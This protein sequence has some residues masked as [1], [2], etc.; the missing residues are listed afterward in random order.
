MNQKPRLNIES[1]L[2]AGPRS[3]VRYCTA[4]CHP[5]E[6]WVCHRERGRGELLGR[7]QYSTVIPFLTYSLLSWV[8]LDF[9][10][11][12]GPFSGHAVVPREL[13]SKAN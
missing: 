13:F 4:A 6:N 7:S 12:H 5:V 9:K 1:T 8:V 2:R 10:T 3:T 11:V